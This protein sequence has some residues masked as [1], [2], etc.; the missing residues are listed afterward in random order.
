[1]TTTERIENSLIAVMLV[2][3]TI[4]FYILGY[5]VS[6]WA[7]GQGLWP[8]GAA[9][10]LFLLVGLIAIAFAAFAFVLGGTQLLGGWLLRRVRGP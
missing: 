9:I 1:M 6:D 5:A 10:R 7:Y 2:G 3:T 4:L 8:I